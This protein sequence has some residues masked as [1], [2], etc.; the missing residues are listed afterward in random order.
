MAQTIHGAVSI[1]TIGPGF[2]T[3]PGDPKTGKPYLQLDFAD[4]VQVCI[5]ATLA[6]LIGGA[7]RGAAARYR[8]LLAAGRI[9]GTH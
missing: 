8:D 6:D 3:D 2:T 9:D 1:T 4:G 7:G 5:T